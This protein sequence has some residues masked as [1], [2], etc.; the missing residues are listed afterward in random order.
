M[1][2]LFEYL[3]KDLIDGDIGME[4][5]TEG[6][7]LQIPPPQIWATE[8]DGSLRGAFPIQ[9][10]EYVLRKPLPYKGVEKALNVLNKTQAA[11]KLNFSF[12]TS[13]HVHMNVLNLN[14]VQI[15]NTIYTY[16][17]LEPV[18][19]EYCGKERQ[20]NRFC[21]RLSDAE[22]LMEY[23]R[24][25]IKKGF[26]FSTG[27]GGDAVRYA[28]INLAAIGRYGSL[29]FRGMRGTMDPQIL[30]PWVRVLL[31]IRSFAEKSKDPL[32][33]RDIV[34]KIGPQA[35]MEKI[36]GEDAPL[37]IKDDS[38]QKFASAYSLSYDIPLEYSLHITKA[39][40]LKELR[41]EIAGIEVKNGMSKED[42]NKVRD[43]A[44]EHNDQELYQK[45]RVVTRFGQQAKQVFAR[46][47]MIFDEVGADEV[48]PEP[49]ML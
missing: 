25:H 6:E 28:A 4:I 8:D 20:G 3:R 44:I 29:E 38:V 16:L 10:A 36:F 17:L 37:F 19:F 33:I 5:E 47:L 30:L 49:D 23:V 32:E 34:E 26:A 21:L 7:D 35:F 39:E 13:C 12:R 24:E 46:P 31:N 14:E 40:R 1:K 2:K 27:I 22:F 45:L 11:A 48:H 18:L 43:F 9:R 15:T 42:Y 41:K